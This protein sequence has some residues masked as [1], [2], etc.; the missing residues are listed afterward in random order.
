[1]N[2]SFKYL[3]EIRKRNTNS[4]DGIKHMY[5]ATQEAGQEGS[6][7]P[8]DGHRV[9]K[10]TNVLSGLFIFCTSIRTKPVRKSVITF[11]ILYK[12]SC[13]QLQI[14]SKF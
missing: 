13:G 3:E 5:N 4:K 9:I 7:S 14:M 10:R 8:A 6:F 11:L 12:F 2:L 1:M